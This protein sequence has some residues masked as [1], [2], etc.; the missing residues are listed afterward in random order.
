MHKYKVHRP[1][2]RYILSLI[3]IR[4]KERTNRPFIAFVTDFFKGN[5]HCPYFFLLMWM[6]EV[7][8]SLTVPTYPVKIKTII[9]VGSEDQDNNNNSGV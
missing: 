6:P 1:H 7:V 9:T 4:T 5:L 8:L 3:I 2:Q